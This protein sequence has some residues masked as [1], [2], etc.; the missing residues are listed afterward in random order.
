[1]A[2]YQPVGPKHPKKDQGSKLSTEVGED[3]GTSEHRLNPQREEKTVL[4]GELI[5]GGQGGAGSPGSPASEE[6]QL[7][8]QGD[9]SLGRGEQRY[10]WALPT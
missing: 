3:I 4:A 6:S 1:M 2:P 8:P 10:H 9:P 7:Y 5:S